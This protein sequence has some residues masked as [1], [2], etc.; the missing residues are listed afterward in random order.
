[1]FYIL[2]QK[3]VNFMASFKK[4]KSGW[5]YR[6]SY[7]ESGSYKTKSANGFSTKKE[8]ELA[9]AKVEANIF[10]GYDIRQ[11]D[12]LFTV[13]FREWYELYRK[14]K[15]SI[16][17]DNDIERAVRFAEKELTG[18][19]LKDL[20]RKDYQAALNRYGINHATASVKKRHTY[21][22]ACLHD[23]LEE[24]IIY[25]DPTYKVTVKGT[26][27]P[28]DSDM[29]FLNYGQVVKLTENLLDDI[30]PNY[31]SRFII[32]FGLATGARYAEIIGVTWD[33]VDFE[34]KTVKI[35]KTWDYKH[36]LA[37]SQT[38][39]DQSQRIIPIDVY[40]MKLLKD[41][42]LHQRKMKLKNGHTNKYNL[43]F[44]NDQHELVSN[45]AVNKTLKKMCKKI[46]AHPITCHSLRHTHASLLLYDGIDV[47]TVAKR[48]GHSTPVTTIEIYQ[49][50][51][52]ELAQKN[53]MK[54]NDMMNNIYQKNAK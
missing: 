16:T 49:H 11:A 44:I 29:K 13:H 23:A 24:G 26:V 14:G 36:T 34:N 39:N 28:K 47:N 38:K 25:R 20:T 42:K 37:F 31:L 50:I 45:T 43:V 1:M 52:D 27:P 32:L 30:K 18:I 12:E 9:A 15:H 41:L 3:G 51:V 33:C 35:E 7:K 19:K 2:P 40:T 46:D 10:K 22:K 4:L 54:L 5:Q 17:N 53:T 21:M 8:A 6:V 48:L